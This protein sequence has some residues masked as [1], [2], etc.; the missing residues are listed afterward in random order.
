M[1]E[2]FAELEYSSQKAVLVDHTR[3]LLNQVIRRQ[4]PAI[5]FIRQHRPVTVLLSVI[6]EQAEIPFSHIREGELTDENFANLT[7][8]VGNIAGSPLKICDASQRES[9]K[10]ACTTLILS[11]WDGLVLCDWVLEEDEIAVAEDLTAN[12]NIS[13]VS[14]Y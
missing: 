2:D 6:C 14:P 5:W 4:V 7:V 13:F 11:K 9:F 12:R 8:W 1:K 10:N 3:I